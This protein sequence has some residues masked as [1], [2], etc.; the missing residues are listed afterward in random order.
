M[1]VVDPPRRNPV[2]LTKEGART[3]FDA[4]LK[5]SLAAAAAA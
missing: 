5:G 1:A 3:L 4:A 2:P